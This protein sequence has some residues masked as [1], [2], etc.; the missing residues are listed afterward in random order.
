M[1]VAEL[2]H[3]PARFLRHLPELL[4][5][6]LAVCVQLRLAGWLIECEAARR[7]AALRCAIRGLAVLVAVWVAFGVAGS[8]PTFYRIFPSSPLL[9][10][11]RGAA[12]AWTFAAFGAFVILA[13]W[14]RVPRQFTE[15]RRRFFHAAGAAFVTA[16]FAVAAFGILVQRRDFRLREVRVPISNLP[17]D[18]DGL[19]IAHLSDIHLSPFLSERELAQ[20]VGMANELRPHLAVVTGDLITSAGDPLGGCLRQLAKLRAQAGTFG[21]LGN[22]EIYAGAEDAAA[23]QGA[24]LGIGFLRQQARILRFGN[25]SLNLVGVD[26]QKMGGNYLAGAG[27]WIVPGAVNILLSHNP[28][29]FDVAAG[30][31]WDLTLAGHTHGGQVN[32]EILN[33]S[34]NP[35]RF[36]TPYVYGLYCQGRSSIWV[37]RGLGTVAMPARL[38]AP[39]EVAL[40]RL[41]A[42]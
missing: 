14:R 11:T 10:W 2:M 26:Y 12:L 24:R 21:C 37:T 32:V 22:H 23:A 36:F 1:V 31:G 25:A 27:R 4:G 42:T 15:E 3:L 40:I 19:R 8:F 30:Q 9:Y 35:A 34:W 38:G 17:Q 20:A 33:Q 29:V 28:D 5:L 13:V 6:A 39:P 41:C 7:S 18:L 16:P